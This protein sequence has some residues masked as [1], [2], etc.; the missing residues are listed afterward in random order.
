MHLIFWLLASLHSSHVLSLTPILTPKLP[1]DT[2][3]IIGD[4]SDQLFPLTSGS[5][6]GALS[7]STPTLRNGEHTCDDNPYGN[8]NLGSCRRALATI[9]DTTEILTVGKI[10]PRVPGVNITVPSRFIGRKQKPNF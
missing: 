6:S 5:S 2:R 4:V 1:P 7:S 10:R 9:P 8:P 3:F